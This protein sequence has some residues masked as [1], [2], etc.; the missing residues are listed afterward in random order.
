M[1]CRHG[2]PVLPLLDGLETARKLLKVLLQVSVCVL[3]QDWHRRRLVPLREPVQCL[4]SGR[5]K[6][7][8]RKSLKVAQLL[9]CTQ[10]LRRDIIIDIIF[11]P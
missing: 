1:Q 8:L 7:Y 3:V 11:F 5:S 4:L 10:A 9:N 2:C 6:V